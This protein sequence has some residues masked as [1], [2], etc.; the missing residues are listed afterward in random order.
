V[1]LVGLL[2]GNDLT[3][4]GAVVIA[5]SIFAPN[6]S[7]CVFLVH[8]ERPHGRTSPLL[9]P[10]R[11]KTFSIQACHNATYGSAAKVLGKN[12]AHH[13]SFFRDNDSFV[14][15]QPVAVRR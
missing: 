10:R 2:P 7:T 3:I 13:R 9:S 4:L 11:S 14:V 1:L 6:E 12:P 5:S 15:F 8:Q